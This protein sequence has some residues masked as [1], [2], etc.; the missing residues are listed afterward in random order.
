MSETAKLTPEEIETAVKRCYSTWGDSYYED[1]YGSSAPYPPVHLPLI[2]EIV[3]KASPKRLLDAGCGPASM[4]RHMVRPERQV[5]GFDLTPEMIG[6]AQKVMS[7]LN[8]PKHHIWQGSITDS[9]AF[10]CPGARAENYDLILSFGVLPHLQEG[11]EIQVIRNLYDS[12]KPGGTAVVEARNEL[13]SLFTLNR[14]S[15]EFFLNRLI[16]A[17]NLIARSNSEA[18][19]LEEAILQLDKM[20]RTDLPAIRIGKQGEP[21][22][23]EVVSRLHNPLV[24]GK[25]F[26]EAGFTQLR[27]LFYHYHC[28]PPMVSDK[29]PQLFRRESLTMEAD[30]ED[31]RGHFM[32]S[33]FVVVATRT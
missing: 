12:L 33:A 27:T 18:S 3:D 17:P 8:V 16:D 2:T 15:K 29:V 32:A 22:Y 20:F 11:D 7:T 25:Q 19:G 10:D 28:L 13:F 1:Y 4:L 6:E 9:K 26:V 14:Y 5:Y 30:P 21:G 23:D 24:L 31:W